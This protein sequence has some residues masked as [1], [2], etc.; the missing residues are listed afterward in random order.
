MDKLN[1]IMLIDDSEAD[2]FIHQRIIN[3][4]QVAKEIV[5]MYRATDAL[6]YLKSQTRPELIFLDINMPG[7]D[8]WEFLEEYEQLTAAQKA[9]FIICM[10]TTS[11]SAIDREKAEQYGI[12]EHF[13]S[14]PLT[15]E[16]LITI[17][18]AHFP[19]MTIDN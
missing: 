19:E 11:K 5:I 3:K 14:K 12:V 9:D 2:N 13:M 10:L 17:V 16:K 7:M 15:K 1:K 4:C 8:G 18:K 6:D